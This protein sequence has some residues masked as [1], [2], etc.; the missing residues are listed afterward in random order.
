MRIFL[1]DLA[2]FCR[3]EAGDPIYENAVPH[4]YMILELLTVLEWNSR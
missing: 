1:A 3:S 4:I 2:L